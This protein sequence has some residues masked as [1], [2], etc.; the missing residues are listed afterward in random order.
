V[1]QPGRG[2]QWSVTNFGISLRGD[3]RFKAGIFR[4]SGWF[5]CHVSR[6]SITVSLTMFSTP[7]GQPAI[8]KTGCSSN[9]GDVSFKLHGGASFIYNLFRDKIARII[10]DYL[11]GQM[12]KTASDVVQKANEYLK[13][14]KVKV[15]VGRL[16]ELNYGLV[17]NPVFGAGYF[18]LAT[19]GEFFFVGDITDAPFHPSPLPNPPTAPRMLAFWL[20]DYVLN[21]A[22]YVTHKHD[23]LH[24]NFTKN[25][26]PPS[27]THLLDASCCPRCGCIGKILPPIGDK[28]P[29]STVEIELATTAPPTVNFQPGKAT[30]EIAGLATLRARLI[31][32]SLAYVM[33][34]KVTGF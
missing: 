8:T 23:A 13:H 15:P 14:F 10:K 24:H 28:Y 21:T 31:N 4:D 2:L 30:V 22:G 19:R 25:D 18:E 5:E 20:S 1:V 12:C 34:L 3:W 32:R 26:L 29:N 9:V 27:D 7:S 16:L 11:Q 17:S 6:L 33:K